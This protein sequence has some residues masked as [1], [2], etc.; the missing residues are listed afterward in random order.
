MIVLDAIVLIAHFES[1]D[2]H[3]ERAT[4]LLLDAADESLGASLLTLAEVLV[5]PA[6]VGKLDEA[7]QRF[8]GRRSPP[9]ASRKTRRSGWPPC[10]Q[11][12]DSACPTAVCCSRRRPRT[13]RL[14]P[15]TCSRRVAG[16]SLLTLAEVLVG[17]ARVGKLDEAQAALR[18]LEIATLGFAEDAPERLASMRAKVSTPLARLRR[19]ARG[20]DHER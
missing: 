9:S 16:A 8:A 4:R 14:R 10:E 13:L 2:A 5:G 12:F 17:P 11:G 18:Q 20:G 6:R 3:H 19:A 7:Q 1:T 15:L